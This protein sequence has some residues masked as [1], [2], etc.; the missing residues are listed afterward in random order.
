MKYHH[1]LVAY[2]GSET[3]KKALAHAIKIVENQ[4]IC[5]LTVAHVLNRPPYAIASYGLVLPEGYQEKIQEYE[6]AL[7]Q[8]ATEQIQNLPYAKIAMLKGNPA[9]AILDHANENA[10][11]LIVMG[12]RG[13]GAI[14]EWMLGSV[15]H[16]VVQQARM[17][18]LIVK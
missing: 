1:I 15:S 4:P 18:V 7:M 10:C 5:K 2:D 14:K 17:P 13:L 12:N 9:S 6:N 11:D 8:Q 3:S 16:H